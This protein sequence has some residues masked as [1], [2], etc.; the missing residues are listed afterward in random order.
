[1]IPRLSNPA[2]G[3]ASAGH[4]LL[5]L[6]LLV[7]LLAGCAVGPDFKKPDAPHAAAF[8]R[9]AF[10][11]VTTS[12]PTTVGQSQR[13]LPG[14]ELP[15]DWWRLFESTELNA[16]VQESFKANPTVEAAQAALRQAHAM[17][18]AQRGNYLPKVTAGYTPTRGRASGE[19][20]LTLHTAQVSVGFTPDVFG[21]NRRAVE[22]L[23]ASADV[24]RFALEAT[25]L[26]LA[27]NV[28]STAVEQA[29]V[30]EQI[31]AT[32]SIIEANNR[33][34]R[35]LRRQFELGYAAGV[36]VA[37]GESALAQSEQALPDLQKQLEH[38]RNAMAALLGRL[39]TEAPEHQFALDGLK[40]PQELPLSLPSRLVDQRPDVRVAA[41]ELHAASAQIGVAS[42]NMLPQFSITA[43]RG[44]AAAAFGQ[45]FASGNPFWSLAAEVSQTLFAGGTLMYEKRAAQ[46]AFDQAAAQYKEAVIAAFHDV[47]DTLYALNSDA[48][49]LAATVRSERAAQRALSLVQKQLAGG[50]V[51]ALA[52]MASQ[53]TYQEAVIARV[54]AQ[55]ARLSDTA[56][57]FQSLGGGWWQREQKVATAAAE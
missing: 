37:L 21:G 24:Q 23:M 2:G 20:P 7:A 25:Y 6:P 31:A 54:Q 27:T 40:L 39:P 53:Q 8:T 26:T 33:S 52:L 15:E 47:S 9:D 5:T 50:Q 13:F 36:D 48:E 19:S 35:I 45:M 42:A 55:A 57:L 17:V 43:A 12:A 41:A 22:A 11:S 34:L 10:P 28:V 56:A 51:D 32:Q 46:A 16:L 38:T 18:K 3:A 1:M 44:G 4:R 14:A 30:R 29:S 49:T